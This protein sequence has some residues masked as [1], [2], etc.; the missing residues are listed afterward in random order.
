MTGSVAE[1]RVRVFV[2]KRIGYTQDS[3]DDYLNFRVPNI[4]VID[5][6]K[7]LG[8]VVTA[9]GWATAIHGIM[10]TADARVAM[11]LREVL[12]P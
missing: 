3:L 6:W 2:G 11:P 8:W 7:H 5:P 12:L 1:V 10:R 9:S 4:W